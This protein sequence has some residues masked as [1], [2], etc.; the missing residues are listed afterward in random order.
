MG[1]IQSAKKNLQN[2]YINL[3]AKSISDRVFVIESDDWGS[4]RMP[5][6]D[7]YSKVS[8]EFRDLDSYTKYDSLA[9][10]EDFDRLFDVLGSVRDEDNR[11]AIL[12]AN[13]VV[14]NPDFERIRASNFTEY[15][16]ETFLKTQHR[17]G[18]QNV[19]EKWK[20][21]IQRSLIKPQ[22]HGR[23]HVNIRRWMNH[24]AESKSSLRKSFDHQMICIEEA[25][26]IN[27]AGFMKGCDYNTLNEAA[28]VSSILKEGYDIFSEVFGFKSLTFIANCYTWGDLVEEGLAES[29]VKLIQ[30]IS[31]QRVPQIGS[32][33][34][35]LYKF[36]YTG[37]L[38]KFGQVYLVRNVFFEP[39]LS[40][41]LNWVDD[42]MRRIDIAFR[43]GVPAIVGSHR[44]NY[45][46]RIDS[47]N[48]DRTLYL[49]K[50]L[51]DKVVKRWP[52]VKFLSSDELTRYY[53]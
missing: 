32:E 10:T 29:G 12:T 15:H 43:W 51:L 6:V 31:K 36:H 24:L 30:G 38:N 25:A 3:R 39:S 17:Y 26:G 46:G 40:P 45:I 34:S 49:L 5:N 47:G 21:G 35:Y 7:T 48:R 1:L 44:L 9:D 33:G 37:E 8:S 41:R 42:A 52:D 53:L 18:L 14:A 23:E 20:E 19:F 28:E 11:P 4:I 2:H 16:F 13:T 27:E 22:Y 50:I